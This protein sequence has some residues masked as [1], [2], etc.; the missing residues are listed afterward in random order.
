MSDGYC[1]SRSHDLDAYEIMPSESTPRM[2]SGKSSKMCA[3]FLRILFAI[4]I[5][6]T[7]CFL[8]ARDVQ[9]DRRLAARL[10]RFF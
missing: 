10:S 6:S 2:R 7:Y 3:C 4:V 9:A 8:R 1:R 5:S